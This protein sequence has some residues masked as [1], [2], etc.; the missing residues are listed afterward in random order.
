MKHLKTYEKFNWG[1]P[2]K[3]KENNT[4]NKQEIMEIFYDLT[5]D[6]DFKVELGKTYKGNI[7]YESI[8]I[9]EIKKDNFDKMD[10]TVSETILRLIDYLGDDCILITIY[11]VTSEQS[12]YQSEKHQDS[13]K[14][15][16]RRFSIKKMHQ[17]K[18]IDNIYIFIGNPIENR[19]K[20][21]N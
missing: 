11:G 2:F 20:Y 15:S 7:L 3:K 17:F 5:D 18:I 12:H 1:I 16:P 9:S 6:G 19:N 21:N 14:M 13:L 8:K 10:K 4:I